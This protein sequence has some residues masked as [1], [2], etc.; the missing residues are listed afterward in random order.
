MFHDI[1]Q[2]CVKLVL[3][4]LTWNYMYNS[5][6]HSLSLKCPSY[7]VPVCV[8]ITCDSGQEK[9][10]GKKMSKKKEWNSLPPTVQLSTPII[11]SAYDD[12][13]E[14]FSS[15][16]LF[17]FT[18]FV[19]SLWL[20]HMTHITILPPAPQIRSSLSPLLSFTVLLL[21]LSFF[22][23]LSVC[24]V[25]RSHWTWT[26]V[27]LTYNEWVAHWLIHFYLILHNPWVKLGTFHSP[28]PSCT[29]L[30]IH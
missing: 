17:F 2:T 28:L 13:S 5:L 22:L 9:A 1:I 21:L 26:R 27:R 12:E 6:I 30:T 4:F 18:A 14:V 11:N 25:S 7:R 19:R 29:I 15:L 10:R 3:F 23:L 16:S 8:V 20:R 24:I